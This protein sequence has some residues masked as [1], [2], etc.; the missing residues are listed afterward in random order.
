MV[1]FSSV[2]VL[3]I[4]PGGRATCTL[5][6]QAYTSCLDVGLQLVLLLCHCSVAAKRF[7]FV[8]YLYGQVRHVAVN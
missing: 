7:S 3:I 5:G 8:S 1:L 2:L 6:L 4:L